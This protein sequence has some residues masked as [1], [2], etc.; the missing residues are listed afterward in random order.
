MSFL[1]FLYE[2][3]GLIKATDTFRG[4]SFMVIEVG[5]NEIK[6]D[7]LFIFFLPSAESPNISKETEK[8]RSDVDRLVESK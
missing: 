8:H 3:K 2:A 6:R 5:E 4:F 1:C 7:L